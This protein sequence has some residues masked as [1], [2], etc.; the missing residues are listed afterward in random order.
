MLK[1]FKAKNKR[2]T[3]LTLKAST[4]L[5]VHICNWVNDLVKYQQV[6]SRR[7]SFV[8]EL[9]NSPRRSRGIAPR[10]DSAP[11]RFSS[12][13]KR[14]YKVNGYGHMHAQPQVKLIDLQASMPKPLVPKEEE[15]EV[16]EIKDL[17]DLPFYILESIQHIIDRKVGERLEDEM[18]AFKDE[19][20]HHYEDQ[21]VQ[22]Q[23][24]INNHLVRPQDARAMMA[25][26][27]L[28]QRP[29]TAKDPPV[30]PGYNPYQWG[31]PYYY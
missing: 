7:H 9:T 30:H 23:L 2:F 26:N 4:N 31:R 19:L 6:K 21:K 15:K 20:K 17:D 22:N 12:Q 29:L 24:K 3:P 27:K 16:E 14:G 18:K 8:R 25:T 11:Y 10:A 5:G 13:T 1:Q 28:L